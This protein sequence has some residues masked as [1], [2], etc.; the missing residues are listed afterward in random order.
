MRETKTVS[1]PDFPGTRNRDR[2]RLF[3]IT[4]WPAARA[5]HWGMRMILAANKGAGALPLDLAGIGMEGIAILGINTFLRG[6]IGDDTLIPLL[7]ELLECVELIRDPA[8]PHIVSKIA[9]DED[10]EEVPTRMWLRGEVLSLHLNFSVGA[11]FSALY[12]KIMTV[13]EEDPP[14]PKP[15]MSPPESLQ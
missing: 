8:K 1:V 3:K 15:S 9:L 4:E 12:R 7:D 11:A 5:E 14:L 6:Q 10:I 13:T 2:G